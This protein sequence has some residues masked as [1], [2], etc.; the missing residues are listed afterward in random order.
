M[1][2]WP[3]T[4]PTREMW[5]L[6]KRPSHSD[7]CPSADLVS[8]YRKGRPAWRAHRSIPVVTSG[9]I[10][11]LAPARVFYKRRYLLLAWLAAHPERGYLGEPAHW[12]FLEKRK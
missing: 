4:P 5:R 11:R 8:T 3:G 7:S 2:T 12:Q 10:C 1:R 9:L 6:E